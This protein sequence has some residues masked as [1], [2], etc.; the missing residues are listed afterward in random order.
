ML[1]LFEKQVMKQ[2]HGD[3]ACGLLINTAGYT[4]LAFLIWRL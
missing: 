4:R 1:A 3:K 2:L